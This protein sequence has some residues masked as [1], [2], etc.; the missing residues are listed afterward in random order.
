MMTS[1]IGFLFIASF[2]VYA[3]EVIQF[4][5]NHLEAA[6]LEVMGKKWR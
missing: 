3:A 1:V 4:S 6:I 5:D 2:N